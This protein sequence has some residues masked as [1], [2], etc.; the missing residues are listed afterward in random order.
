LYINSFSKY[1]TSTYFLYFGW[2]PAIAI[3][4]TVGHFTKADASSIPVFS[5]ASTSRN[6]GLTYT[7]SNVQVDPFT[8]QTISKS[9]LDNFAEK[10]MRHVILGGEF[11]PAKFLSLRIGYNY[12][13]R[14]E[15]K[16]D[17]RPGTVGFFIWIWIK[18]FKIQYQLFRASYEL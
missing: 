2:S 5:P 14:Q 3:R 15:M 18:C 11:I 12:Q 1:W 6:V 16:I 8:G 7:N 9:P 10:A 4:N 13:R 17:T